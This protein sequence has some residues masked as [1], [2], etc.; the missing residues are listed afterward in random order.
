MS[1]SHAAP[2]TRP[3]ADQSV[4]YNKS[5]ARRMEG[6]PKVPP[7]GRAGRSQFRA[8]RWARA[9]AMYLMTYLDEETGKVVY[10][11]KA[12]ALCG[13]WRGAFRCACAACSHTPQK[14]GP[15]SKPTVSAHP[16]RFSPD[17]KFSRVR[18]TARSAFGS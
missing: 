16:A 15:G 1:A 7:S 4:H 13:V 9:A 3:D 12:R 17:D 6:P 14:M 11:L 5:C 2:E 18:K 10:T 8:P